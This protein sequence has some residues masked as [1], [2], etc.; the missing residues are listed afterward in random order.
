MR[1]KKM[2]KIIKLSFTT[3]RITKIKLPKEGTDKYK[4]K[5]EQGFYLSVGKGGSK[6]FYLQKKID[7]IPR[8]IKI[9]KFPYI[10]LDEARAKLFDLKREIEQGNNPSAKLPEQSNEPTFK[11]LYEKYMNEYVVYNVSDTAK[12]DIQHRI[13]KHA[14]YLYNLK[15]SSITKEGMQTLHAKVSK[16][17]KYTANRLIEALSAI[18]NKGIEW[19]LLEINPCA[20]VR[21]HKEKSRDRFLSNEEMPVFFKA[22]E[23]EPNEQVRDFIKLCLYTGARQRNVK[24]MAWENISFENKTWYMPSSTTKNGDSQL[25][26]LMNEALKILERRKKQS[27]S[28]WLFPSSTSK[29]GHIEEPKKVWYQILQR[30]GIKNLRMH[31]LRRTLGSWMAINGASSYV[32]GKALSHKNSRSTDVYARLNNDPVR[33]FMDKA[34]SSI[35]RA[36]SNGY[37]NNKEESIKQLKEK[38][39]TLKQ[40]TKLLEDELKQLEEE[41]QNANKQEK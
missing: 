28:K 32:I 23:E 1:K 24:S 25:L 33:E 16:N 15:L 21:K 19:D 39:N 40:Q 17:G 31:D 37:S 27:D 22:L 34:I 18:F 10:S 38:I 29:S 4:D 20:K 3:E 35:K 8:P 41:Y 14:T 13:S 26:P 30:A 36:K 7:G 5:N 12:K 9:G 2:S 11:E 6:T